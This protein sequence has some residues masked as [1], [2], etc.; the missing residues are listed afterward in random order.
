MIV[1]ELK[2]EMMVRGVIIY[3]V[4]ALRLAARG[5]VVVRPYKNTSK[6]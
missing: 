2:Q 5:M 3:G 6:I 4:V 1:R